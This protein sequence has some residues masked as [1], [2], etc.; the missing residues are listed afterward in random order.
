MPYHGL[1]GWFKRVDPPFWGCVEKIECCFI[2]FIPYLS[3]KNSYIQRML[4]SFSFPKAVVLSF[5]V[6][7]V[8]LALLYGWT[9]CSL[10]LLCSLVHYGV[11]GIKSN[12]WHLTLPLHHTQTSLIFPCL[13]FAGIDC[14]KLE[15]TVFGW[16]DL[17]LHRPCTCCIITVRVNFIF[18]KNYTDPFPHLYHDY[19]RIDASMRR[20]FLASFGTERSLAAGIHCILC[21][22]ALML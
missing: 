7:C 12:F 9:A 21:S 14:G 3:L 13:P 11:Y 5:S 1:F 8:K 15:K 2:N 10:P 18:F 22:S 16:S 17:H 19:T 6:L 20:I 4:V